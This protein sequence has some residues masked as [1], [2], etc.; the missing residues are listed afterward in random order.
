ML[1]KCFKGLVLLT[2][3]SLLSLVL[4]QAQ[5]A[6]KISLADL[7]SELEVTFPDALK[8]ELTPI[9]ESYNKQKSPKALAYA[10]NGS[11]YF[12]VGTS[13]KA[14]SHLAAAQAATRACDEYRTNT[15]NNNNIV[16]PCEVVLLDNAVIKLGAAFK[17]GLTEKTPSSVWRISDISTNNSIY[18]AGTM[19]ILK[20]TLLPLPAVYDAIF[21]QADRLALETNPLLFTDPKR[22]AKFQAI[23]S[24]NKKEV[25]DAMSRKLRK[26]AVKFL[27][28]LGVAKD[29]VFSTSPSML[30]TQIASIKLSSLGY[31]I[32][33]GVD[34]AYARQAS[35]EGKAIL[36]VEDFEIALA[37][38]TDW[39]MSTQMKILQQSLQ[40]KKD[41]HKELEQLIE[42]WLSGEIH[43]LYA[44]ARKDLD[45]DPDLK[46]IADRL[47][48]E[49][50]LGM[51]D[52]I[53]IYLTHP[54]TTTVMVGAGHLGGPKGLVTL[55]T[56][57]G[58]L[59]Q[60]LN[61]AGEPI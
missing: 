20:P 36:E 28:S 25:K 8:T 26:K 48:D 18:L 43:Q 12:A 15:T 6:K 54:E 3:A 27:K 46:P 59:V 44:L 39:P 10:G 13:V 4:T 16:S 57:R 9:L 33:T 31:N 38:L 11:G 21:H 35:V 5:A 30:S 53:E 32:D 37:A 7:E 2:T 51:L 19:H 52:Q 47:Y 61:H 22:I 24:V 50:N 34:A 23:G 41:Q 45:R 29:T 17:I 60:Q 49:R 42:H 56:E 40:E 1:K 14:R 58:Y 55:L